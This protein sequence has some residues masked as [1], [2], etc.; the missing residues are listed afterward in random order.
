MKPW[1]NKVRVG[2]ECCPGIVWEPIRKNEFTRNSSGNAWPQSS[3]LTKPLWTDP[4]LKKKEVESKCVS[5]S[6][7]KKKKSLGKERIVKNFPPKSWQARKNPTPKTKHNLLPCLPD[8]L[9]LSSKADVISISRVWC[10]PMAW[11]IER[12]HM[13]ISTEV[14]QGNEKK[15]VNQ[16][17]LHLYNKAA[18]H[19]FYCTSP[20]VNVMCQCYIQWCTRT[21]WNSVHKWGLF[22]KGV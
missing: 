7:L 19:C 14:L 5:W 16:N 8:S 2:L 10:E 12:N 20:C 13:N 22:Q 11:Q 21:V 1:T 18:R 4:G 9:Q 17:S 6:P 3:Q 15:Q